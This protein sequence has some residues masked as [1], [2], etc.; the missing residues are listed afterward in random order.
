MERRR[1]SHHDLLSALETATGKE[2]KVISAILQL[3]Q[4]PIVVSREEMSDAYGALLSREMDG[5][6]LPG[7]D[8][9]ELAAPEPELSM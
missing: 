9:P 4:E 8:L 6:P 5:I 2:N 7:Q 3:E 1:L